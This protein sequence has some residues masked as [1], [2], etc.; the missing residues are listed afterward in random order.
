M[1]KKVKNHLTIG[2]LPYYIFPLFPVF[3]HFRVR[4]EKSYFSA[5]GILS[6]LRFHEYNIEIVQGTEKMCNLQH[7]GFKK[8]WRLHLLLSEQLK[9]KWSKYNVTKYIK[10][11]I[12]VLI[13]KSFLKD[14]KTKRTI[15]KCNI[16]K[17]INPPNRLFPTSIKKAG[18]RRPLI[19]LVPQYTIL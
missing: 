4:N 10:I 8:V 11:M 5:W 16:I 6:K 17:V 2:V 18:W 14:R 13:C 9:N 1:W 3:A 19:F 15:G 7:E 12:Y